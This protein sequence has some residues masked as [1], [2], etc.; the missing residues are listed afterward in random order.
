M[1]SLTSAERA[2]LIN[3]VFCVRIGRNFIPPLVIFPKSK[4][5]LQL[6]KGVEDEILV[7]HIEVH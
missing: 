1:D 4:L 3:V 6:T 5:S 2:S 7:R